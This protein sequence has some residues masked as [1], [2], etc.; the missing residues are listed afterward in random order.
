MDRVI[1][2]IW[3]PR[4]MAFIV[5]AVIVLLITGCTGSS[6]PGRAAPSIQSVLPES[7]TTS[8]TALPTTS[9]ESSTSTL[10][11]AAGLPSG[12]YTDGPVGTPHYVILLHSGPGTGLSGDISFLYQDGRTTAV[13]TFTG[14]LQPGGSLQLKS[15]S[16]SYAGTYG[17]SRFTLSNCQIYLR[18][19]RSINDC[20]FTHS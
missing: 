10:T 12:L 1:L 3:R 17:S 9:S 2:P 4:P 6:G 13:L 7:T 20:S 11:T 16:A 19:I 8:T 5:T 14:A 18:F 15:G